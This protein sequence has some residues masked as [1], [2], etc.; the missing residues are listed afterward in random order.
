VADRLRRLPGVREAW[1]GLT[2]AAEPQL[3]AV[4]ATEHTPAELRAALQ[5]VTAAWL[6]PKKL[7]V[8]SALPVTARGKTDVRAL[9]GMVS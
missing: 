6:I 3:A 7:V 5:P 9:Q 2:A 8:V 1:A 4:V